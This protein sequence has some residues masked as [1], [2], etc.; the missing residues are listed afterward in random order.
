[1]KNETELMTLQETHSKNFDS[2]KN[3]LLEFSQQNIKECKLEKSEYGWFIFDHKVTGYELNKNLDTIGE[4]FTNINAVVHKIIS[5]FQIIYNTFDT[6]DQEYI[7][8]ILV[9]LKIAYGASE[10]AKK[11]VK[12]LKNEHE[13]LKNFA[14]IINNTLQKK[15][16][17]IKDLKEMQKQIENRI[18]SISNSLRHLQDYQTDNSAEIKTLK[19]KFNDSQNKIKN[20]EDKIDKFQ[21]DIKILQNNSDN[22]KADVND[23]S[24]TIKK[25]N[26]RIESKSKDIDALQSGFEKLE[27][28]NN[29][30]KET[31]EKIN[32]N[33]L[34][35]SSKVSRYTVF[36][37]ITI[38]ACTVATICSTIAI[39]VSKGF[40]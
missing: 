24:A 31:L 33:I 25:T 29:E 39:L 23:I 38:I 14:Q 11:A 16:D 15:S 4:T 18:K 12:G 28:Q 5:E 36:S 26:D 7:Q 3:Q 13:N 22:L 2:A 21:K 17:E 10:N 27:D 1:M 34:S 20:L 8:R 35:T 19:N 30:L 9:N 32:K 6:L 40:I 37:K